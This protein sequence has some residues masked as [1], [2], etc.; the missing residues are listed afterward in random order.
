M[1]IRQVDED[2]DWTFGKGKNDYVRGNDAVIQ[3][4][5]TRLQMFLGD[6]FFD[7]GNGID[8]FN[9][10]GEKD[11]T[12]LNLFISAVIMNTQNVNGLLQLAVNLS[13]DRNL[14]VRYAVQSSF[15]VTTGTFQFDL[16]GISG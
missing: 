4:I 11:Q 2:N 13:A 15:S 14:T 12:A 9:A 1:I 7:L 5:S 6:C 3:N 16:N 10:L 8:W